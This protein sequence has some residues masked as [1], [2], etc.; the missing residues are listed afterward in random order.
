V[1]LTDPTYNEVFTRSA[2]A[3][4]VSASIPDLLYMLQLNNTIKSVDFI[5]ANL[6]AV[7]AVVD[8]F[9]LARDNANNPEINIQNYSSGSLVRFNYGDSLEALAQRYLGDS[10][11]WIDIA[12]ANGLK[13]PYIDEI[14]VTVPLKTNGGG[15][16]ITLAQTDSNGQDNFS[17]LYVNQFSYS[18]TPNCFLTSER[19]SI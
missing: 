13:P 5:L 3:P 15:N 11:S 8:P 7:D 9:T 16:T 17:T 1:G 19:S 12:I 10:N 2:I 4:Q 18:Q 6:F 14:G